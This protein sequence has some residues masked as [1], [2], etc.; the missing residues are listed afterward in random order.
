MELKE[1]TTALYDWAEQDNEHRSVVC[2]ATEKINETEE[3]YTLSTSTAINCKT[4]PM[5]QALVDMMQEDKKLADLITKAFLTYTK[6]FLTYTME[7]KTPVGI[8][9]ITLNGKEG[10]D[11]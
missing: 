10:S 4:Q 3:G 8:G 6:A 7:H 1:I 11:E 2:I 5:T 9:I